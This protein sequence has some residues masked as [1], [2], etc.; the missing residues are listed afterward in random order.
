MKKDNEHP[1]WI[2]DEDKPS[3]ISKRE[4]VI[5]DCSRY[6]EIIKELEDTK[7]YIQGPSTYHRGHGGYDMSYEGG[8]A[9]YPNNHELVDDYL[10]DRFWNNDLRFWHEKCKLLNPRSVAWNI[11]SNY[12][13]NN[14]NLL[15]LFATLK[16]GDNESKRLEELECAKAII[17]Q[18]ANSGLSKE[19]IRTI[20]DHAWPDFGFYAIEGLGCTDIVETGQEY[21]I[22]EMEELIQKCKSTG[23]S[24]PKDISS[25]YNS[26]ALAKNNG[27]VLVLARQVHEMTK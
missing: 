11:I 10:D 14:I 25:I 16:I 8:N 26:R 6:K 4:V 12:Y 21:N 20:I 1:I 13:Q 9:I 22:E 27:K 7:N 3:I 17:N 18:L 23:A 5:T 2:T 15:Y 19:T 24:I